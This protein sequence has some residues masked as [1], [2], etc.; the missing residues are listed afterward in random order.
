M[1]IGEW[2]AVLLRGPLRSS[3]VREGRQGRRPLLDAAY[4]PVRRRGMELR[5]CLLSFSI[6]ALLRLRLVAALHIYRGFVSLLCVNFRGLPVWLHYIP[7]T[8]FRT[9]NQPFKVRVRVAS[10]SRGGVWVII[11]TTFSGCSLT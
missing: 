3:A 11:L 9:N 7:G 4:R 1:F 8:V 5:V 2:V 6:F 10:E